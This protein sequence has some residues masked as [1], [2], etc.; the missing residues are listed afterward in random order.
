MPE[1]VLSKQIGPFTGGVWIL[2]IGGGVVLAIFLRKGF[3]NASPQAMPIV[4]EN[5]PL[6][7]GNTTG[8]TGNPGSGSGGSTGDVPINRIDPDQLVPPVR[9][10]PVVPPVAGPKPNPLPLPKPI[11]PP[12]AV[13]PKPT[14]T[15][16]TAVPAQITLGQTV[17]LTW[18]TTGADAISLTRPAGM[19]YVSANGSTFAKPGLVGT[20]TYTI[21]ARN[22]S[23]TVT[24]S[25]QVTVK[26]AGASPP[27]PSSSNVPGGYST[28]CDLGM[29]PIPADHPAD[30]D[31]AIVAWMNSYMLGADRGRGRALAWV[32]EGIGD[33]KLQ[34][35]AK[36]VANPLSWPYINTRRRTRGL[37][38]LTTS[39]FQALSAAIT[40]QAKTGRD[41]FPDHFVLG[42]WNTYHIPYLC[43]NSPRNTQARLV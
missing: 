37:R 1:S 43:R 36:F 20:F 32:V 35:Y 4:V 7:G 17:L 39:Q 13:K 40:A 8:G 23:G 12:P 9:V 25:V 19:T 34:S 15:L 6:K 26:G 38:A 42:L 31:A 24:K 30:N 11:P 5:V 16:F 21:G 22:T 14:I 10:P 3:G 29:G 28:T 33:A 18:A 41:A 2:V 27:L